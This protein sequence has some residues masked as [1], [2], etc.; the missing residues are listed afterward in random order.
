MTIW[1]IIIGGAAGLAL[2]GPI[3]ALV[4][5]AASAVAEHQIRRHLDPRQS[6]NVAFTVAVI[7][8]CAKLAKADGTVSTPEI[9]AFRSRVDIA[10]ED[11]RRVGQ[12]WDLARQTKDGFQAY[13]HQAAGLFGTQSAI[14]EQLMDLLFTIARADGRIT[15]P[16]WDYLTEVADIFGYDEAGFDRLTQ[17]YSGQNPPPHLVLGIAE[18]SDF[19]TIRSAWKQLA[20]K[21]HPDQLIAAGMPHEFIAVATDRLARINQAYELL[22]AQK[23]A[24]H[25]AHHTG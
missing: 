7:A 5:A 18:N 20:R 22:S 1:S 4:G 12:F 3:G 8:L 13:A 24:A 21:H 9:Q 16:E 23:K 15:A 17:L 2:G 19:D 11:V 25:S 14:L 10:P 6:Q